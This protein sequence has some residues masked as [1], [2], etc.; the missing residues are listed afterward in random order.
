MPEPE[1]MPPDGSLPRDAG[2]PDR[3]PPPDGAAAPADAA[4]PADLPLPVPGSDASPDLPPTANCGTGT[5]DIS[6][7]SSA[8]GI[9]IDTDG[10]IY[11]LTDDATNSYVGRIRPG[12]APELKW[13]SVPN[14]PVTWGL[15]LDSARKRIYVLVVAS[16]GSLVAF[17]NITGTPT[18]RT[19]A[20]GLNNAN[21]VV[22]ASDGTVYW[23]NQGDRH[24]YRVGPS[25]GTPVKVTKT[26]LGD[27][28][29]LQAPSGVTLDPTNGNLLVGLEHGGPLYRL[30][31]TNGLES[32]RTTVGAW[33]GW[34][35]GLTYDLRNRLYV[36]I[37]DDTNP[38]N[39]VRLEAD[40]RATVMLSGG[41]F[42]SLA[43]GRGALDCHDLYATDP[44]G[45][46][47]KVRIDDVY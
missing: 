40:G 35:N 37:Y 20:T 5:A 21:D 32:S 10:T 18:R 2:A 34:A 19:A 30:G 3:A 39:V 4:P 15:G 31:L 47:R 27:P 26:A 43:F 44:F 45:P 36:G 8:D 13:Q 33:S 25:G 16:N 14:S 17:E 42:S 11:V 22:V 1:P 46:M 29:Q 6:G 38:R 28:A 24:I 7:I 12:Q 23:S 41:R 9:V